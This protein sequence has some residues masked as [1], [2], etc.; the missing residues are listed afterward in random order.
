MFG[1]NK[2][3]QK[4]VIESFVD[5]KCN[6]KGDMNFESGL[7]IDGTVTGNV[8]GLKGSSNLIVGHS[9]QINGKVEADT[10]YIDGTVSGPVIAHTNVVIRAHG[11]VRGN[12]SYGRIQMEDGAL[13]EGQL[14]PLGVEPDSDPVAQNTPD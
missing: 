12:V 2:A 10:I 3:P 8:F 13:V 1:T 9:A 6:F 5:A 11:K 7:Q 14:I 4:M